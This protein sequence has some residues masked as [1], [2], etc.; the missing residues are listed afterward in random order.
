MGLSNNLS[1]LPITF[2]A[3]SN[4]YNTSSLNMYWSVLLRYLKS[5][6]FFFRLLEP[7]SAARNSSIFASMSANRF[8]L[9]VFVGGV[10]AARFSESVDFP[11]YCLSLILRPTWSSFINCLLIFDADIN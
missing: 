10:F 1:L 11:K 5:A 3:I 9:F 6:A 8:L 2:F 7:S 4:L